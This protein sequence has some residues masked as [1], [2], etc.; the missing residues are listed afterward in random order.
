MRCESARRSISD[1]LDGIPAAGRKAR[2]ERHL[3]G[4]PSCRAYLRD[5]ETLAGGIRARPSDDPPPEFWTDFERRLAERMAS[6][7]MPSGERA[8]TPPRLRK[9]AWAG[10][11]SLVVAAALIY[12]AFLRTGGAPETPWL[13]NGS[14]LAWILMEADDDPALSIVLD[15]EVRASIDELTGGPG[16]D[17]GVPFAADPLFWEGLSEEELQFI[18]SEMEAE[19]DRGDRP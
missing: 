15:R 16:E 5:L 12:I 7:Q 6:L 3:E 14:S 11:A 19:T 2:L 18:A 4:C 10:A 17:F 1:R 9:W 13:L 8:V